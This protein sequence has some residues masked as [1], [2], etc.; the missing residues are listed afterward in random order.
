MKK[1]TFLQLSVAF[2]YLAMIIVNALANILPINDN[3]T[4]AVSNFYS[5]LFAPAPLTFSIWGV[6]YFLL[7]AYTLYQFGLFQKDKG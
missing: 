6:I 4:G 3:N 7:A 5:N 2:T 1:E